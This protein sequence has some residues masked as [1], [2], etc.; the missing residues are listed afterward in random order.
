MLIHV[1]CRVAKFLVEHLVGSREAEA[2]ET[3]YLAL[4][5]GTDEE[6]LQVDRKTSGHTEDLSTCGHYAL[7]I[8]QRLVAEDALGGHAHDAHLHAILAQQ[9]STSHEGRD[10]R[11]S[12]YQHNIRILVASSHDVTALASLFIVVAFGQIRNVLTAED[13]GC[14]GLHVLHS[15]SPSR[16]GLLGIGRTQHEARVLTMMVLQF[17]HQANLCFLFHRLVGRTILTYAEGIVC[18]DKLHGQ[19]HQCSHAHGGLHVVGEYEEGTASGNDTTMQRHTDAAASHCQLSHTSLEE[20][21]REVA[22]L[23]GVGLLQEAIGLVGVRKVGGSTNHV[24]HLFCQY[25][26]TSGTCG[27][28][29]IVV[30]LHTL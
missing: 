20:G 15:H 4:G 23:E 6:T 8:S 14:R 2:F 11:T 27:A 5:S 24:G 29:G 26:K 17:L 18:P 28:C 3:P 30:L 13:K 7:L 9:L 25:A 21:T 12:S 10:L 22:C 19:L 1:L 16:G